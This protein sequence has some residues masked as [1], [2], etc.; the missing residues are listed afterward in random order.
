MKSSFPYLVD[1]SVSSMCPYG[2]SFCYTSSIV[3]GQPADWH[4]LIKLPEVLRKA[5]VFEVVFGGGEPTLYQGKY[6]AENIAELVEKFKREEFKVGITTKNY[7]FYQSNVFKK[8]IEKLDSIAISANSAE[9]L[10]KA[11][12]LQIKIK[13]LNYRCS[14]YIQC[15]LGVQTWPEF[16]DFLDLCASSGVNLTI[17]G[18]KDF[19]FGKSAPAED[20]PD[21]WIDYVK[22][23]EIR[24]GADSIL[25]NKYREKLIAAGVKDYY[26]VGKEGQSSC[27]IDA[28][29]Q[30][31]KPSSFTEE[32]YDFRMAGWNNDHS[33]EFLNIFGKF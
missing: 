23:K 28:V 18:Y 32:K 24:V 17:L 11:L 7:K 16:R 15:V 3:N 30:V 33:K 26:L 10:S 20:I 2:C 31:V 29:N 8:T 22:K 6:S 5:G 27:Y 21:E 12:I 4:Y 14:V 19:G 25:I 13:E 9:D 1:C